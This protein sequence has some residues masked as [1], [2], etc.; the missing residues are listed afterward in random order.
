M[1]VPASVY[2]LRVNW[3]YS[4][5][6]KIDAFAAIGTVE[7]PSSYILHAERTALN[8]LS[9]A[10]G[11]ATKFRIDALFGRADNLNQ[12]K[13]GH[14][15]RGHICGTRKTTPG[16]RLVEK[17]SLAVGGISMHRNDLSHLVM[18]KDN[19]IHLL[20]QKGNLL[21]DIVRI[22]YKRY[23]IPTEIAPRT[24]LED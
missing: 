2:I 6:D 9:R 4:E 10:S 21:I 17:Y 19:H 18:L 11:I 3:N 12:L 20:R 14:R 8:I 16:F 24:V 1:Q 7:G 23:C 13:L 22:F 15:W 5:G